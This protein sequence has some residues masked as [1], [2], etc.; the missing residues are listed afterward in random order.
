M[1]SC[2][3]KYENIPYVPVDIT[4]YLHSPE[5]H[6]LTTPTGSI[7]VTGGAYNNGI[8]V[9]RKSE[10]E[11]GAYDRTC[12]YDPDVGVVTFDKNWTTIVEDTVCGSKFDIMNEIVLQGPATRFLKRYNTTYEQ[13][14]GI[15]YIYN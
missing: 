8:I 11:F 7:I 5:Y 4:L 1:F 10:N 12:P 15:L 9:V 6:Q 3:D 14:S 2:N 13:S